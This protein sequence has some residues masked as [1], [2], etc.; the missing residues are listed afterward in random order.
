MELTK[1]EVE[2]IAGFIGQH[3]QEFVA[4]VEDV[5]TVTALHRLAEKLGLESA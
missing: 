5:T 3:W 1:E 2:L 4:S